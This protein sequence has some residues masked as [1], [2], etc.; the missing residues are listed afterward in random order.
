MS[1]ETVYLPISLMELNHE[2]RTPLTG[3]L[4][5]AYQ[6]DDEPLTPQQRSYVNDIKQAGINLLNLANLIAQAKKI[7]CEDNENKTLLK[8]TTS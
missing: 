8:L 5:M 6:L 4:G 1:T 3:I 2:L 7:T